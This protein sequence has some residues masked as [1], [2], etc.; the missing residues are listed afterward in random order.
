MNG[1]GTF[2][3]SWTSMTNVDS[4]YDIKA[5]RYVAG[6]PVGPEFLVNTNSPGAQ[7]EPDVAVDSAGNFVIVWDSWD[8][9]GG[10]EECTDDSL[11]P[12]EPAHR[13]NPHQCDDGVQPGKA[14][15]QVS[16]RR[17]LRSCVGILEARPGSPR[18]IWRVR[19]TLRCQRD[20]RGRR[21]SGQYVRSQ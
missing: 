19:E 16:S 2:V 18:R 20:S 1:K 21:V 10:D 5:R 6:V 8:Q 15:S 13:R 7:T 4:S 3:V 12:M 14:C 11:V 17:P 9:D